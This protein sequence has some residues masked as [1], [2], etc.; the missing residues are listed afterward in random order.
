MRASS[1]VAVIGGG[2]AGMAAAVELAAAG[3][4]VTV[5]EASQQLG[6]ARGASIIATP[7]STMDCTF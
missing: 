3:I 7:S 1:K 6:A 5:F 2:Y 4:A